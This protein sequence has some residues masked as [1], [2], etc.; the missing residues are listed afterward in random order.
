MLQD[1]YVAIKQ[2]KIINYNIIIIIYINYEKSNFINRTFNLL[3]GNI[4]YMYPVRSAF[5][6][7]RSKKIKFKTDNHVCIN[8]YV[9]NCNF[10]RRIAK[11]RKKL[12]AMSRLRMSRRICATRMKMTILFVMFIQNTP[13]FCR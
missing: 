13:A 9:H 1:K 5:S 10:H 7:F 11:K 6:L 12:V 3:T 4:I 2:I 8:L